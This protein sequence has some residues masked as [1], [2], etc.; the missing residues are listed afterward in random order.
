MIT[1]TRGRPLSMASPLQKQSTEL[2]LNS[3]LAERLSKEISHSAE[4]EKGLCPMDPAAFEKAGE[5]FVFIKL[6]ILLL[7]YK[8]LILLI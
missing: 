4:R 2:L 1:T 3:T 8:L 5:T 7:F 6:T